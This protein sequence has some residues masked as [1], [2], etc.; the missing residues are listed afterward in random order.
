M[1]VSHSLYFPDVTTAISATLFNWAT[2]A[3]HAIVLAM[4]TLTLQIGA[5][6][7]PASV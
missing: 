1:Q 7:E 4:R 2:I 6:T 5:T 3:N